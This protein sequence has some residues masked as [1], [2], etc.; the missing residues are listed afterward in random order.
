MGLKVAHFSD[1]HYSPDRLK[2]AD[3]CFT[4]A[5]TAAICLGVD[6]AIITGD[7]TDHAMDAHSPAVKA[8]ADQ[9]RHLSNHCPVLMLQGTFSHEPPGFLKLLSMV[10]GKFPVSVADGIGQ[11]MLT[12][13]AFK[14]YNNFEIPRLVVSAMPTLNKAHIAA[15]VENVADEASIGTRAVV[16]NVIREWGAM[17]DQMREKGIPSVVISHGTVFNSVTEHGVP[18]AGVDHELGIDTLFDSRA[19]AIMLGHI[20]KH[21]S[22]DRQLL[23]SKGVTNQ[24]IAY[25]GS[26]GRFHFG[27]ECEKGWLLWDIDAETGAQFTMTPTPSRRN[28]EFVFDG[29]PDMNELT[30]RRSEC[31]G[32]YVRVR[33]AVDEEHWH[34]IDRAEIKRILSNAA[35]VKIEGER[36]VIQ[37]QRAAGISKVSMAEKLVM[38][39]NHT[40]TPNPKALQER[41]EM[42]QADQ[43]ETVAQKIIAGLVPASV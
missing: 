1:L 9:I 2:E 14:P 4:S 28:V 22:W 15:L 29:P 21:Q 11:W 6:C 20:H 13:N 32:A 8:L 42:I 43:A 41:L 3:S 12:G 17:H 39:A 40:Q 37:R 34:R 35:E 19:D 25:A 30:V 5:V 36:L 18:M 27:E 24:V 33:Y 38:W 26:I 16:S 23:T 7:S 31:D 10:A